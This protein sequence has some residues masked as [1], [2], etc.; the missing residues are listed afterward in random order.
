MK[1]ERVVWW[2]VL[3]WFDLKSGKGGGN[4]GGEV[5]WGEEEMLLFDEEGLGG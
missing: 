4:W 1:I 3:S 5:R 2:V